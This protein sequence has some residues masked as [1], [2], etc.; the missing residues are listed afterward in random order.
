MEILM[1]RQALQFR[2][3]Y[4]LNDQFSTMGTERVAQADC[5]ANRIGGQDCSAIP[6]EFGRIQPHDSSIDI[7]IT[8]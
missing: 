3:T 8:T 1:P 5:A 4:P 2:T 6:R 7:E